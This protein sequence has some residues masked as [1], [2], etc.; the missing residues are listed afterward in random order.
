M[1]EVNVT[2]V[3]DTASQWLN[4]YGRC[5]SRGEY[6]GR[7]FW[8]LLGYVVTAFVMGGLIGWAAFN[9]GYFMAALF[10]LCAGAVYLLLVI[11]AVILVVQRLRALDAHW[12]FAFLLLLPPVNFLMIIALGIIGPKPQTAAQ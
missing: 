3:Q 5:D 6:W 8:L 7:I 1:S 10:G 4:I 9:L 2:Q 12:A 11:A